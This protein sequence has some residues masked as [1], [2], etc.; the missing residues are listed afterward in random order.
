MRLLF[1]TQSYRTTKCDCR[2]EACRIE[3]TD[4]GV[5]SPDECR[6]LWHWQ[7]SFVGKLLDFDDFAI[8]ISLYIVT[9]NKR[10][11]Q[12]SFFKDFLNYTTLF[13]FHVGALSTDWS[14]IFVCETYFRRHAL[15][16]CDCDSVDFSDGSGVIRIL[17]FLRCISDSNYFLRL[18]F[19]R[20]TFMLAVAIL[21]EA[22]QTRGEPKRNRFLRTVT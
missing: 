7:W 13:C 10:K 6:F 18:C 14:F 21:S 17:M 22:K 16:R 11:K 5:H 4:F 15:C 19:F 8:R 2:L 9:V 1:Q 3:S 20:F 12:F